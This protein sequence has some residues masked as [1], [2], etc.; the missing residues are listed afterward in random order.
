MPYHY[1]IYHK[2]RARKARTKGLSQ[3]N[4]ILIIGNSHA[5]GC[6][7]NLLHYHGESFEAM[8]NVM[9]GA[10]LQKITQTAKNDIRNLNCKDRV[11]V[12]GGSKDINK[13]ESIEGLKHITDFAVQ[14][15]HTN[16]IIMPALHRYDLLKSSCINTETKTF[17]RK[18]D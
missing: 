3:T 7:E 12:W 16:I 8:G 11:I 14:N 13:N 4:N 18:N 5:R 10:R 15:Q 2:P 17:N 9:P 1:N 6:A